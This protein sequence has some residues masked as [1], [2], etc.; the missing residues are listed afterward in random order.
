MLCRIILEPGARGVGLKMFLTAKA[1]FIDA[2][3][4]YCN[5]TEVF[6]YVNTLVKSPFGLGDPPLL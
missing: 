4:A 1:K 3:S 2:V 5:K 6:T